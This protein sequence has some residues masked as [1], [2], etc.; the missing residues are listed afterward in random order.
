MTRVTSQALNKSYGRGASSDGFGKQAEMMRT[1]RGRAG[2]SRCGQRRQ[3]KLGRRQSTAVYGVPAVI[4]SAP[5]VGGFWSREILL[6]DF[7]SDMFINILSQS[8]CSSCRIKVLVNFNEW[9]NE[10]RLSLLVPCVQLLKIKLY[11]LRSYAFKNIAIGVG[12]LT[13]TLQYRYKFSK[14]IKKLSAIRK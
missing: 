12:V 8:R 9:M 2:R 10:P 14:S 11:A 3:E 4:W 5:I 7:Y 6:L 1:W 13:N